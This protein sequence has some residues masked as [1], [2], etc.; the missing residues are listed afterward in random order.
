MPV[1][2]R[3]SRIGTKHKPFFRV[4]VVDSR[5]KR[6]GEVLE[7]IGTYDAVKGDLV[8]FEADRYDEWVKQGA[9][10]SDSAKKLYRSY[11]KKAAAP[12]Q[13]EK[14]VEKKVAKKAAPKKVAKEEQAPAKEKTSQE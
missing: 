10:P 3:L 7:N 13:E 12:A 9:Q 2:I 6:D 5:K 14:K 1:A 11:K 4:V 8:R